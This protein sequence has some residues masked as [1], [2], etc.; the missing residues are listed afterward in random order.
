MRNYDEDTA[1]LYIGSESMGGSSYL[2][3]V[4]RA[5]EITQ[6]SL[7]GLPLQV[8]VMD[9]QYQDRV[10]DKVADEVAMC[11]RVCRFYRLD[12]NISRG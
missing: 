11:S 7:K 9:G 12:I 8:V 5:Y 4:L 2:A 10:L 6:S 1:T 3:R